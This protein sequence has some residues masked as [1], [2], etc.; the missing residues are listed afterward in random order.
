MYSYF[1]R[2]SS[3]IAVIKA[4]MAVLCVIATKVRSEAWSDCEIVIMGHLFNAFK[5]RR[6]SSTTSAFNRRNSSSGCTLKRASFC[7]KHTAPPS[8]SSDRTKNISNSE[9]I[10][11][12]DLQLMQIKEDLAAF[13]QQDLRF[14]ERMNSLNGSVSK[15]ISSR[16]SSYPSECSNLGSLDEVNE[17]EVFEQTTVKQSKGQRVQ[18]VNSMGTTLTNPPSER[19]CHVR[20][21]TSDPSLLYNL[22][23]EE[24]METQRHSADQAN[25][26]YPQLQ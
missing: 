22:S 5:S 2:I 20:R 23:E 25:N 13:R 21:A 10:D 17:D 24:T 7:S 16:L 4:T 11:A 18:L 26:L 12:V 8:P 19:Y 6:R 9:L 3:L 1:R 14:R 15:L